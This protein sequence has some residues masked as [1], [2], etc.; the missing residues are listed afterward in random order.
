MAVAVKKAEGINFGDLSSYAGGFTLPEGK[1]ALE[2]MFQMHQGTKA[3]GTPAGPNRLGV[4]V[5]AHPLDG[6]EA[7][8]VFY[9]LGSKAA[10]SFM[11]DPD[12]GKSLIPVAGGAGANL[13]NKTNWFILLQSL[14]NA[15]LPQGILSN[16]LT[17]IDG[18]HVQTTNIPEPE[19]RKGFGAQTG[20]A[21]AEPRRAN[22]IPVVTEILEDGKPWE[23]SGGLP[24]ATT[25]KGKAKVTPI[26]GKKAAPAAP[27]AEDGDDDGGT[28]ATAAS[29]IA[30]VLGKSEFANGL[31]KVKLR[32][33]CFKALKAAH[34]EAITNQVMN[35]VFGKDAVLGAV[36]AEMGY[37]LDGMQIK[38]A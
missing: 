1:Y 7:Q 36:L 6:G 32:T 22:L 29:A 5:S 4:M 23:G 17:V 12:T 3:D 28:M 8:K 20:E 31:P 9:S 33:E 16:D 15:G 13:N 10:D 21:A 24:G 37:K 19:E 14:Y 18:M 25:A 38:V 26:A 11:A 30:D 35:E 34:G 2:F 27:V